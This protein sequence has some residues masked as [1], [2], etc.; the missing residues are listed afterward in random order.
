MFVSPLLLSPSNPPPV[1]LGNPPLIPLPKGEDSGCF[2]FQ[3]RE[4]RGCFTFQG[5]R[6]GGSGGLFINYQF[7]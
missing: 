6:L 2:A 1:P 7:V 4:A 5:W 3:G